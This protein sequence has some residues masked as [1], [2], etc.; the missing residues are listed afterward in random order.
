MASSTELKER[1]AAAREEELV[2]R[3][4]H[5]MSEAGKDAG[6][7]FRDDPG[8]TYLPLIDASV[9]AAVESIALNRGEEAPQWTSDPAR[10]LDHS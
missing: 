2:R 6:D 4:A 1:L 9:A 5:W 8:L 7:A 10:F 3:T